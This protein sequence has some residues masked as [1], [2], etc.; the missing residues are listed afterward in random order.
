MDSGG[1]VNSGKEWSDFTFPI[2]PSFLKHLGD[3]LSSNY[4]SIQK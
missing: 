4:S 2:F 1:P 3:F